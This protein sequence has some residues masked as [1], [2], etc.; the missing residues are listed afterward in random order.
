[1]EQYAGTGVAF[2]GWQPEGQLAVAAEMLNAE[3]G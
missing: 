1:M 2:A 3:R